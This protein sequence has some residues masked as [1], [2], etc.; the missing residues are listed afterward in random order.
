MFNSILLFLILTAGT[1]AQSSR[2]SCII[3]ENVCYDYC[4][5]CKEVITEAQVIVQ[6]EEFKY[7]VEAFCGQYTEPMKKMCHMTIERIID[8]FETINPEEFCKWAKLC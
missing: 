7:I 2:P 4:H 6:A 3:E 8:E 5:L 1:N